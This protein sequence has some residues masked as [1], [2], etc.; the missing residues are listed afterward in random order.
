[1]LNSVKPRCCWLELE[2]SRSSLHALTQGSGHVDANLGLYKYIYI[3]IS[4]I[5]YISF[6]P[7]KMDMTDF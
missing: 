4:L 7:F 1:M 5:E 3:S 6:I 2:T